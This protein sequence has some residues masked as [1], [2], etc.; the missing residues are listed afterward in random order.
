ML[1]QKL[2]VYIDECSNSKQQINLC[3]TDAVRLIISTPITAHN[4]LEVIG[5]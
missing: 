2:H 3:D 5:L 4:A 1:S